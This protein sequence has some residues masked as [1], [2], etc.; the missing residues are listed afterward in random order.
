M[1]QL[2]YDLKGFLNFKILKTKK[3]NKN[4]YILRCKL[5]ASLFY[6][7]IIFNAENSH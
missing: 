3:D 7:Y 6:K 1:L 2:Y 5:K 4:V